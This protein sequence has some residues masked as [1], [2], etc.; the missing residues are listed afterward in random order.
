MK[1]LTLLLFSLSIVLYAEGAYAQDNIRIG[2]AQVDITP[3]QPVLI[4]GQF[5][6]R[7]SEGVLDPVTAT[8]LVLESG[9]D[10]ATS[11]KVIF[12]SCDLVSIS[13][14]TRDEEEKSLLTTVRRLVSQKLSEING[15]HIMINATHT[16]AAPYCGTA[17]DIK[18]RYGVDLDAM[19]P[20]A[21]LSFMAG[22]VADAVVEAWEKR[23]PGGISFGLSHAVVGRNRLQA[24][25][26]GS[27]IMYGNTNQP[28]FSH[29]EG[30]EDH[31]VNLIY[32]WDADSNLTG[33][34]MNVPSPSQVSE[35]EYNLSADYWHDVREALREQ[36]GDKLFILAQCSAAGDQSPHIMYDQKGEERMQ[37]L[38][39]PQE[40]PGRGTLARRKQIARDLTHAA[41]SIL[42]YM[43]ENI[44]W[45]PVLKH[46]SEKFQLTRR[47]L[48]QE[49]VTSSAEGAASWKE[50]YDSLLI[51]LRQNPEKM[52]EA[53]WYRD[54]TQA[55]G[56]YRWFEG[57][58]ERFQLEKT[59][60]TVPIE[61]HVVRLG[62]VAIATNPFELYLDYG[63]RMKAQS[64]A[65]QTFV[66]QLTGS[67][68]YVPTRR[69]IQ[70]GA[71]GAVASSTLIGPEGGQELVE[72]TLR[73]INSMW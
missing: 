27:S 16:H 49:D 43:K 69:S 63:V 19:S 34:V 61:V 59:Q 56:R 71:Y 72:G 45:N 42:P 53:R 1:K 36:L 47:L 5:H 48:T 68:S 17:T 7:V 33:I 41:V 32:T 57:V 52:K 58:A 21:Y 26:S 35:H 73:L 12:V 60:K 65:V 62:D 40:K 44:S 67:G 29:I 13:D 14:G 28:D 55:Y 37:Q 38:L 70:G 8:V 4:S 3:D 11:E 6:A 9:S 20:Y 51:G 64:P 24:Q 25:L 46:K 54:I 10:A 22:R 50:R 31:S 2:W 23:K 30:Y 39:F 18:Q 66:V 15:D